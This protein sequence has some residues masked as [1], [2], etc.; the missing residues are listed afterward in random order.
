MRARAEEVLTAGPIKFM[1]LSKEDVFLLKSIT[2]R[3][4]TC[5]R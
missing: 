1:M 3:D 2:E 5:R 4:R